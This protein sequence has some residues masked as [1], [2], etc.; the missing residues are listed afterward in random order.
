MSY[1]H[2]TPATRRH[3]LATSVAIS[4]CSG[5][6]AVA[7]TDYTAPMQVNA[8]DTIVFAPGDTLTQPSSGYALIVSGRGALASGDGLVLRLT[9]QALGGGIQAADEAQVMLR[10]AVIDTASAPHSPMYTLSA[11]AVGSWVQLDGARIQAG[12][13]ANGGGAFNAEGGARMVFNDGTI[14]AGRVD[15]TFELLTVSGA[16]TTMELNRTGINLAGMASLTV[17]SQGRLSL[18]AVTMGGHNGVLGLN[19]SGPGTQLNATAVNLVGARYNVSHGGSVQLQDSSVEN[20]HGSVFMLLG[21]V[22][23]IASA[24]VQGGRFTAGGSYVLNANN[25]SRFTGKDLTWISRDAEAAAWVASDTST[26]TLDHARIETWGQAGSGSGINATGGTTTLRGSTIETHADKAYAV[27]ATGYS[28]STFN[29]FTIEDSQLHTWGAG[30]AGVL[31]GGGT[32]DMRLKQVHVTT[33]GVASAGLLQINTAMLTVTGGSVETRGAN[34]AAFR[35]YSTQ[36]GEHWCNAR[37]DG[38]YLRTSDGDALWLQGANHEVGLQGTEVSASSATDGNRG[39]LLRVSDTLLNDGS[40][41]RTSQI[42]INASAATLNGN[43]RVDSSTA[44]T[45]LRFSDGTKFTGALLASSGMRVSDLHLLD[46]S[47]WNMTGSSE[48]GALTHQGRVVFAPPGPTGDYKQLRIRGDYT[49]LGGRFVLNTELS[50]DHSRTDTVHITGNSAGTASLRIVNAAGVGAATRQGIQVVQVDGHAETR[51]TLEGRVVAGAYE[52]SLHQGGGDT[53]AEGNWYLRSSRSD[54]PDDPVNP[55]LRPEVGIYQTN[56][57]LAAHL[58]DHSLH[59]RLGEADFA[60]RQ[61]DDRAGQAWVRAVRNQLK[62][63]SGSQGLDT[64]ADSDV[65]QMGRELTRWNRRHGRFH[66]G[67]M[68]GIAKAQTHVGSILTGYQAKGKVAGQSLGIYGSWFAKVDQPTGLYVDTW[69]QLGTYHDEVRGGYLQ[70][71]SY[72]AR[73]WTGSVETGYRWRLNTGESTAAYLQPQLQLLYTDYHAGTHV[74]ANGTRVEVS[75]AAGLSTRLGVRMHGHVNE[76]G[77]RRVQPFLTVNWEH[78]ARDNSVAFN[79][80]EMEQ[81]LPRE[82]YEAKLGAEVELGGGWSGWGHMAIQQGAGRYRDVEGQ[83]SVGYF[84]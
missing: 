36:Q 40:S 39:L 32:V 12:R 15:N 41:A 9:G 26:L 22:G 54:T 52:Y 44:D 25:D 62:V 19:V 8:G 20:T 60:E 28:S 42:K 17:V 48:M 2:T 43:V 69:L 73:T 50:G 82:L 33:E 80:V 78:R 74:E 23:A 13:N 68:G 84:W 37:F 16:G 10:N 59:D 58:F 29:R 7:A 67:V 27:R 31:M 5:S 11:S 81:D 1:S 51:F 53:S 46:S 55:I 83:I 47:L 70:S 57:L 24:D 38:G 66:V 75:Q 6:A 76:G 14:T 49:G 72:N 63:S 18:N 4:L 35:S 21:S 34:S 3:A 77:T 79:G 30:G 56:Q 45:H 64:D 65:L 71:E 61:R